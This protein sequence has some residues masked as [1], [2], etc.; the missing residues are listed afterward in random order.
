MGRKGCQVV[1]GVVKGVRMNLREQDLFQ[2]NFSS[3]D[4]PLFDSATLE[5]VD[6]RFG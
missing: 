2:L 6:P 5:L 1:K 4:L 3:L